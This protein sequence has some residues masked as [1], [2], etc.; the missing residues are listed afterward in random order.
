[1]HTDAHLAEGCDRFAAAFEHS[2][3]WEDD[4]W[5]ADPVD[6]EAV[7]GKA[8]TKFYDLLDAI[9]AAKSARSNPANTAKTQARI[10]LFHGPVGCWQNPPDPRLADRRAPAQPSLFRLRADDA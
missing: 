3:T 9:T 8:R 10:L 7:H 5:R 6:V 2:I 4:I 1:M